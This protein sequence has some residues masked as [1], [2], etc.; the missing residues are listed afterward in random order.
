METEVAFAVVHVNVAEAPAVIVVGDAER[1][2]E[3]GAAAACTVT[4]AAEV[5]VPPLPV[6][7]N[8]YCVV[9]DGLTV[10]DPEAATVPMPL[11]IETV[12]AFVVVHVKVAELPAVTVAGV[13]ESDAT[14]AS[15]ELDVGVDVLLPQPDRSPIQTH[16][17]IIDPYLFDKHTFCIP[18][19]PIHERV[20]ISTDLYR[21]G[22]NW[23]PPAFQL[24]LLFL[25][26][27]FE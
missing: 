22:R 3:G 25:L 23:L 1:L 21:L 12:L 2:A 5:T 13:A 10:I 27:H 9:A 20:V 4:V 15:T 17:A 26:W 7:V 18:R 14:G 16:A 24:S 19:N 11:L 6:A 8:V